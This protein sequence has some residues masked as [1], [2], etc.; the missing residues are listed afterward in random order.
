MWEFL[1]D[2]DMLLWRQYLYRGQNTDFSLPGSNYRTILFWDNQ[3]TVHRSWEQTVYFLSLVQQIMLMTTTTMHLNINNSNAGLQC[4]ADAWYAYVIFE[5][6]NS[7]S[8]FGFVI[9]TW[10]L[11]PLSKISSFLRVVRKECWHT[12]RYAP[13]LLFLN[14]QWLKWM[15]RE[16]CTYA[17]S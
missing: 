3:L 6:L 15:R 16:R 8:R 10:S 11:N 12:G 2:T 1:V 13:C 4:G 9:F 7:G 14:L 17:A 5:V